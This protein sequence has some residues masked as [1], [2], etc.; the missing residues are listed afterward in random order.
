MEFKGIE[1]IEHRIRNLQKFF[2]MKGVG[3]EGSLGTTPPYLQVSRMPILLPA[4]EVL[5]NSTL[6]K[7]HSCE[8]TEI[9]PKT[10]IKS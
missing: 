10:S 8:M 2:A 5:V 3:T 6:Q 9:G 7:F 1:H 4:L